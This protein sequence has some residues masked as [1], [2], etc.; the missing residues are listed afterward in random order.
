MTPVRRVVSVETAQMEENKQDEHQ[1]DEQDERD[2]QNEQD[3]QDEQ[4]GNSNH[5]SI[6]STFKSLQQQNQTTPTQLSYETT[7]HLVCSHNNYLP[8]K[9]LHNLLTGKKSLCE[10]AS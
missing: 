7:I 3:E 1:Q 10:F 9:H 8:N 2:E 4:N 5:K 6:L